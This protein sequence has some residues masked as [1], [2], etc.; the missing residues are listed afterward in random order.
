MP[1][2]ELL[3]GFAVATV[4][5]AYMPGPALLY[6]AAQTLARGRRAGFLAMLGIHIGGYAHVLA[7]ALGLAA[8]FELVPDLYLAVK[9]AGAAYLI[10]LGIGLLR[11]RP[12]DTDL[13]QLASKSA[14]RS[15]FESILVEVLNPKVAIF[16][17][18]F[19]PQFVD[20][21][22]LL[23]IW[24]QFL[25]LGVIVNFAF[26]SADLVAVFL[27]STLVARLKASQRA[28]L[29]ARRI[30]GTILIGLGL[31]LAADRS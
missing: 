18:A 24:T 9:F 30:G 8:V 7:A 19:L 12:L 4:I 6:T 15:V 2:W 21:T 11:S 22:A 3:L 25:I 10:W 5:F 17:L 16:Y 20:P 13:P 28:Q 26:S 27:T 1:S 31:R 23:P 29:W 14:R